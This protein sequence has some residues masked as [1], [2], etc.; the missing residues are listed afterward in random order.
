MSTNKMKLD[1]SRKTLSDIFRKHNL[2]NILSADLMTGGEFNS[3]Y[4]IVTDDSKNY[5][6]KIAPSSDVEVLTYEHNLIQS[7]VFA[8]EKLAELKS[9]HVPEI[10][11]YSQS[12]DE[13]YKYLI[14]EFIEGKTLSNSKLTDEE[15]DK[16]M[17]GLGQT[18]AE[19]HN[20][21]VPDGFGY[22]QNGLKETWKDAYLSMVDS[23]IRDGLAKKS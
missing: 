16:V 8:Y 17:Y 11:G 1:I 2:G 10:F 12:S 18:M 21:S 5:V 7:E 3:V 19:I 20:I 14:M 22:L 4:K 6:I 15:T 9:V 23:I 13:P